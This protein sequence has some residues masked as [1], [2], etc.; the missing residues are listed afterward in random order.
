MK[1]N[2]ISNRARTIIMILSAFA[3]AIVLVLCVGYAG[4]L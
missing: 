4:T 1:K 2:R 3:C